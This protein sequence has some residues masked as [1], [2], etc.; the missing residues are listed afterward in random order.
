MHLQN[1]VL[2]RLSWAGGLVAMTWTSMPI[3]P[4]LL[5]I[6]VT[7]DP[8]PVSCC[9]RVRLLAPMTIWVI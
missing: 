9:Q 4:A 5:M 8:P 2:R 1:S 3:S 7:F 6:R